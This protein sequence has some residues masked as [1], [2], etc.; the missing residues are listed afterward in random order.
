MP[1]PPPKREMEEN[2]PDCSTSKRPRPDDAGSI[3]LDFS[4]SRIVLKDVAAPRSNVTYLSPGPGTLE[5]NERVLQWV[6]QVAMRD[7][8]YHVRKCVHGH[9]QAG[10]VAYG[11]RFRYK[12]DSWPHRPIPS[13]LEELRG[14]VHRHT[15]IDFNV[16]LLKVYANT[17][18][19]LGRHQDVDGS[20]QNVACLTFATRPECLR[21]VQWYR[22]KYGAKVVAEMLP[23]AGSLWVMSGDVN[24]R[25]SHRVLPAATSEPDG[26]RVSITFRSILWTEGAMLCQ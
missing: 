25:Y 6:R 12:N 4:D 22:G 23:A 24:E 10:A 26:L 5:V 7:P 16:V 2:A 9:W 18:D 15:C 13:L 1:S 20:A 17:E 21:V 11:E 14:E 19:S 8:L 3:R